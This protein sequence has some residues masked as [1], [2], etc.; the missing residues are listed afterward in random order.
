VIPPVRC[1]EVVADDDDDH[2]APSVSSTDVGDWVAA[3]PRATTAAVVERV[4]RRRLLSRRPDKD[5]PLDETVVFVRDDAVGVQAVAWCPVPPLPYYYP[6]VERF[7]FVFSH[8]DEHTDACAAAEVAIWTCTAGASTPNEP[9]WATLLDRL[10]RWCRTTDAGYRRRYTF[11]TVVARVPVDEVYARLKVRHGHWVQH[12]PE[13]TDAAKHV[14]EELGIAAFLL[15]MWAAAGPARPRF[16]DLGCGNGFLTYVLTHEGCVGYGVDVSARRSWAEY[17]QYDGAVDLRAGA[18]DPSALTVGPGTWLLGNHADELVPWVP[19]IAARSAPDCAFFVLPCC[20]HDLA[21]PYTR[22]PP[23]GGRYAGYVAYI[24]ALG[25]ACGFDVVQQHLRIPTRKNAALVGRRRDPPL[26]VHEREAAIADA[27]ARARYAGFV[28]R[29]SD[30]ER[31]A[32]LHARR[33]LRQA[34]VAAAAAHAPG[35]LSP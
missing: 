15:A 1:A 11:D 30:R 17:A 22:Q 6:P 28:P 12:W 2:A 33:A 25:R 34:R 7:W 26:P 8:Q 20:F 19:L 14:H 4:V 35:P 21:G 10:V 13:R 3:A 23:A 31:G 5:A 32:Q 29:V 18:V 9:R 16:V 24:A 27:L